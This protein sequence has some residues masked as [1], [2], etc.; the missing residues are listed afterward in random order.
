MS[1][2]LAFGE[3]I[4]RTIHALYTPDL[5]SRHAQRI[6]RLLSV[7]WMQSHSGYEFLFP[8]DSDIGLLVVP[9][10]MGVLEPSG[11]GL[12]LLPHQPKLPPSPSAEKVRIFFLVLPSLPSATP[13]RGTAGLD[14]LT[15]KA[16]MPGI[17]TVS[18]LAQH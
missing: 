3:I 15:C 14:T 4:H 5:S 6:G 13:Y 8:S 16:C 1:I 12:Y 18:Q 10:G 17:P 7:S 2:R 9:T 11:N